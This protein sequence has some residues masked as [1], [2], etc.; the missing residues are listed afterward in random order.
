MHML[1]KVSLM[2]F[3]YEF[4][5]TFCFPEENSCSIFK[6]YGIEKVYIYHILTNT[7]S[8][9]KFL[10]VCDPNSDMTEGK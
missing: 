5:E 2:S 4:L 10:F 9:L 6:K 7:D 8:T 1:G 3:T